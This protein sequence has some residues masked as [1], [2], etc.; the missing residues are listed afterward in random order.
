MTTMRGGE[1]RVEPTATPK[2]GLMEIGTR[3]LE[4][5]ARVSHGDESVVAELIDRLE[6]HA[7]EIETLRKEL[8][9][10][11]EERDRLEGELEMAQSWVRELALQLEEAHKR[12][13]THSLRARIGA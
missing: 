2:G 8:A 6:Y 13:R 5:E 12:D 10:V 4:A 7:S 9:A 11:R 3:P 1:Q